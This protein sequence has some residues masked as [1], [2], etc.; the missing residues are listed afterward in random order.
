MPE[1][2]STQLYFLHP[3]PELYFAKGTKAFEANDLPTA[4]KYLTRAMGLAPENTLIICQL[5][6]CYTEKANYE[7]SNE[8][9]NRALKIDH[10]PYFYYFMANNYAYL[11]NFKQAIYYSRR[12]LQEKPRGEYAAVSRELL[13]VLEERFEAEKEVEAVKPL[14]RER[15]P[16]EQA[17]QQVIEIVD[18]YVRDGYI[19]KAIRYLEQ[20]RLTDDLPVY[21]IELSVLYNRQNR[22][23]EAL[24]L[25]DQ[26]EAQY[27]GHYLARCQRAVSA[28]YAGQWSLFNTYA[29]ELATVYPFTSHEQLEGAIVK[30]LARDYAGALTMF[31]KLN[32]ATGSHR[33]FYFYASKAAHYQGNKP[34]SNYYWQ[35]FGN[36]DFEEPYANIWLTHPQAEAVRESEEQLLRCLQSDKQVERLCGLVQLTQ[37]PNK[38]E[39]M[40]F[41]LHFSPNQFNELEKGFCTTPSHTAPKGEQPT[42]AFANGQLALAN[43]TELMR[44]GYK[45]TRETLPLYRLLFSYVTD[46]TDRKV[47]CDQ[48]EQPL[49]LAALLYQFKQATDKKVTK[50]ALMQQ[51]EISQSQL[52]KFIKKIQ[53]YC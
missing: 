51:F 40:H 22:K 24:Q 1:S 33:K 17:Q 53:A 3:T 18:N 28:Y 26:V 21:A 31:T 32:E 47:H 23:K 25:L 41:S 43:A 9:L 11:A 38:I 42:L 30:T 45:V 20:S 6:I 15:T 7:K 49:L 16:L 4:I 36:Y 44:L 5:A 48:V 2:K 52:N 35:Q 10:K 13:R 12:Y 37:S 34:L 46:Q 8:L 29:T 50:R 39:Y 19:I 27:E 14:V